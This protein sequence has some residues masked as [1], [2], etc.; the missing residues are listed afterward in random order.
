MHRLRI[1]L[2]LV[3][4]VLF[5][6]GSALSAATGLPL[7]ADGQA[8]ARIVIPDEPLPVHQFAAEELQYH[9]ERSSGAK[10]PICREQD[11]A[12]DDSG[13]VFLGPCRRPIQRDV[14]NEG[15][16]PNGFRIRLVDGS[17]Y[18]IG[19]DSDGPVIAANSIASLHKNQTRVGTLFAVY[20]FLEV[21]LGVRW[22]WPGRLGE[23]IPKN[24]SIVVEP[25]EQVRQPQLVHSRMRDYGFRYINGW[26]SQQAARQYTFDV[27]RWMRRHRMALGIDMDAS[28]A[29]TRWW[30]EYGKEHPN[31]FALQPNNQR[32]PGGNPQFVQMCVSQPF[33]WKEIVARWKSSLPKTPTSH[34][35]RASSKPGA[36]PAYLIDVSEN[37]S[38]GSTPSCTCKPCRAWDGPGGHLSDR[39]AKFW[40]AV[41]REAEKIR[42]NAQVITIAYDSYYQPPKET[43][44]N[45]RIIIGIVPGFYFPWSDHNRQQF[46]EQWQGW[47]DTGA[48]LF[49]RPNWLHFGH[50]FPFNFARKLGE[51]FSFAHQRGMI[52]TDFDLI[53]APW[54]TQGLTYYVL[55]R[56]HRHP[57]LPI[58]TILAEYY[59]GFGPA[60]KQVQAYFAHWEQITDSI[61]PEI[62]ARG[63]TAKGIGDNAEHK[64]YLWGNH[65][66]NEQTMARG[67]ELLDAAK[68][69]ASDDCAA[70]QR[71]A[72][73]EMGLTD[74]EL[75]LA[76]QQAYERFQAGAAPKVYVDTLTRLD[77]HRRKIEPHNAAA[78]GWLRGRE[79]GWNRSIAREMVRLPGQPLADPVRLMWDPDGNGKSK[80]WHRPGTDDSSWHTI[81]TS[82][83]WE[84][85]SAGRQWEADHG[86]PYDGVAWYRIRFLAPRAKERERYRLVFGAV[87]KA[88][89]V[90]LNGKL[91]ATRPFPFQGDQGSPDRPFEVDVTA[92][93]KMA[94]HNL[95]AVAV[96]DHSSVGGLTGPVHLDRMRLPSAEGNLI[97]N[98]SFERGTSEW[99]RST[100]VGEFTYK[101]DRETR[102]NGEASGVLICNERLSERHPQIRKRAW[103]R[104]YQKVA[105]QSGQPYRLTARVKTSPNFRGEVRIWFAG[106]DNELS[107]GPTQGLWKQLSLNNVS[108]DGA[109]AQV[110]LNV[111]DGTGK[112]WFDAI[113]VVP[114]EIPIR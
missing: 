46:R 70:E 28:H 18:L 17:L 16:R 24:R 66:F 82:A 64:L 93:L 4:M 91:V 53:P 58:D 23:V 112:V 61:T 19:D 79:P 63:H 22:L 36:L 89:R 60:S 10:L 11:V 96:D 25:W 55:A 113:E 13:C 59:D 51:D 72:F 109:S 38:D 69:A 9:L 74:A 86:K 3:G 111:M 15:L 49:L 88:C 104:F 68:T 95:L 40:L 106:G 81:E 7:V 57:E 2:T 80:G 83:A 76:T 21:Q 41:Q 52:A 54:A 92:A 8:L 102:F 71:V 6:P 84:E 47:A 5:L 62:Y 107:T 34:R 75:T 43:K 42:P 97:R 110:Y 90:W 33:L 14:K 48:R 31:W 87:S 35:R 108:T 65:F 67:K 73:L 85:Q 56:I 78:M 32:G 50:N 37:D 39:Y 98:G 99:Q 94:D 114:I 44:L 101:E 29:F 100:M 105:V 20:E 30:Q 103:A 1:T 27:A 77:T 12:T 45:D 26:A